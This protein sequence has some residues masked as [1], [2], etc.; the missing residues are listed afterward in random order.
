MSLLLPS[1]KMGKV[2]LTNNGTWRKDEN[3]GIDRR[4]EKGKK[5]DDLSSSQPRR[6]CILLT[7]GRARGCYAGGCQERNLA[8]SSVGA[9]HQ[10][11]SYRTVIPEKTTLPDNHLVKL[12][13][14]ILFLQLL[15]TVFV[16]LR[17][18]INSSIITVIR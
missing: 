3:G 10:V 12:R 16:R 14:G 6:G 15:K 11:P 8:G 17:I 9:D 5:D 4:G 7:T 13:I 18:R 1:V 2:K